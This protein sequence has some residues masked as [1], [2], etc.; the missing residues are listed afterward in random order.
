M[1]L[2][3]K[4]ER[5]G[6]EITVST[7][8]SGRHVVVTGGG[9]GIGAA[10]VRRFAARGDKVSIFDRDIG[11]AEKVA[12][13]VRDAGGQAQGIECDITDRAQIDHAVAKATKT[14]GSILV[15]INNAG[16]DKISPFAT[17]APDIWGRII[18]IN[19]YGTLNMTHAVLP[20][21]IEA[22]YGRIVSISSDAGRVG[23]SGSS[24]YS[25]C[26]GGMIAF[27]KTLARETA[28][29]GITV[30]VVCPG[31]TPTALLAEAVE[32]ARDP[33]KMMEGLKRAIPMGRLGDP[34]DLP[35]AI[36]F[37]AS[38]EASYVTGQVISVSGGLTF[39]G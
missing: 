36:C 38:D 22:G 15:L 23:S 14:F 16:Y 24:I 6:K 21:M 10:T 39:V 31:P 3:R 17:S 13:S 26:K 37:F 33:E 12:A 35:G 1:T 28:K 18:D 5:Q 32:S 30:N 4:Q 25:W 7:T 34:E 9:N 8:S 11:A 2:G 19:I 20:G 27:S 29:Q